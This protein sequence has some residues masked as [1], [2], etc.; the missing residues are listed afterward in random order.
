MS[1]RVEY[2]TAYELERQLSKSIERISGNI[3]RQHKIRREI[4]KLRKQRRQIDAV[5]DDVKQWFEDTEE[6][7]EE[8]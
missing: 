8:E 7:E 1:K 2:N 3:E 6:E 4:I 5:P